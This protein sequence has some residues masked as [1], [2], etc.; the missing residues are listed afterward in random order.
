ML[1]IQILFQRN[2]FSRQDISYNEKMAYIAAYCYEISSWTQ[3]KYKKDSIK[4]E[5]TQLIAWKI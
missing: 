5:N 3:F 4:H 2:K 1:R